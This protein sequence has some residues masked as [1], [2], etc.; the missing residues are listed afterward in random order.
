MNAT[1]NSLFDKMVSEAMEMVGNHGWKD[2][3]QNAVTLAAFG[4]MTNKIK[5]Q[6]DRLV[7]PAWAIASSIGLA[8]IWWIIST[9]LGLR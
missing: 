1:E 3:P 2:A 8:A 7:K 4:M 5:G 9:I 6:I